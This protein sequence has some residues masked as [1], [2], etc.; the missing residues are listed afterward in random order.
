MLETASGRRM[1]WMLETAGQ[2]RR[3]ELRLQPPASLPGALVSLLRALV[4]SLLKALVVSSLL[5]AL[6]VSSESLY[7]AGKCKEK[8][9]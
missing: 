2:T 9:R 6:V 1:L 5:W 7:K 8:I 4:S 3:A